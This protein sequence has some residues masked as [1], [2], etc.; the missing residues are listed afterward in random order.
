VKIRD[1][2]GGF[3]SFSNT[4]DNS[5]SS[6]SSSGGG[7]QS[8]AGQNSGGRNSSGGQDSRAS[9]GTSNAN[10]DVNDASPTRSNPGNSSGLNPTNSP[11]INPGK[12]PTKS[13]KPN[14]RDRFTPTRWLPKYYVPPKQP[15]FH[16]LPSEPGFR[17]ELCSDH[18]PVV[19]CG[20]LKV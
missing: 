20:V 11:R 1:R 5:S 2:V 8:G 12:A 19:L 6:S 10:A 16:K 13:T 15:P 18:R 17:S 9:T 3:K 14:S 4:G 7:G